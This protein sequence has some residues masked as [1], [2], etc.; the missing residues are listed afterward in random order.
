MLLLFAGLPLALGSYWT[1]VPAALQAVLLILR[2]CAE[3][4]LLHTELPGYAEYAQKVR[5][6]LAPA[7]W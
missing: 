1:L 2:T 4:R 5:W 3:D 7:L 6:R